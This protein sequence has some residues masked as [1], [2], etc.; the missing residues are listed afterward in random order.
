MRE[1]VAL[2]INLP[3][4]RVQVWFKNRRAK[5]RQQGKQ[6]QNTS[7]DKSTII[8]TKSPTKSP[9]AGG[10]KMGVSPSSSPVSTVARDSPVSTVARDSP[11]KMERPSPPP[12]FGAHHPLLSGRHSPDSPLSY[13]FATS[14]VSSTSNISSTP[15]P[16]L[17]PHTTYNPIWSPALSPNGN[18][19]EMISS[20]GGYLPSEKGGYAALGGAYGTSSYNCYYTNMDYLPHPATMSHA[21][22]N[23]P[24]TQGSNNH[25]LTS[26]NPS[27]SHLPPLK[28]AGSALPL[29]RVQDS[30]APLECPVDPTTSHNEITHNPWK[31]QSFQAL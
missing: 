26:Y 4:S 28:P 13:R 15:S 18:G 16:S 22:L 20:S 14:H 1:E 11:F 12:P 6:Q 8:K 27:S 3:E 31:Y 30:P 24:A 23:V 25:H 7:A 10:P 9:L 5:C 21:S 29:S 2:K 17:H 19:G